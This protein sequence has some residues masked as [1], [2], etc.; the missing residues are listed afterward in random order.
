MEIAHE[1][2]RIDKMTA[3][4]NHS[5]AVKKALSVTNDAARRPLLSEIVES[6][7]QSI[8]RNADQKSSSI[9]TTVVVE[10]LPEI[11]RETIARYQTRERV[12]ARNARIAQ[13]LAS[14]P[15]KKKS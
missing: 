12:Q 9:A 2:T 3:Q 1:S 4:D 10:A 5:A 11:R 14:Q 13:K 7:E 8:Q 15:K 6:S